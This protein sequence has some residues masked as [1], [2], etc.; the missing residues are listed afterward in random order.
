MRRHTLKGVASAA[1]EADTPAFQAGVGH[2]PMITDVDHVGV[3]VRSLD[4]ALAFYRDA[5]GLPLVKEED[6]PARGARVALLAAGASYVEIIQP[7]SPASPFAEHIAERGEG[8]HHLALRSD[9]IDAD[10]TRLRQLGVALA[11][12][13]PRQGITGRLSYLAPEAFDGAQIEVVQPE[14]GMDGRTPAASRI[15]R[16]DH[17]VL[18]AP[19]VPEVS[20][21]FQEWFGIVTKRTMERGTRRFAFMR[22]GEV[23][24]EVIGPLAPGAAGSGLV[25]G[26]AFEVKGIDALAASLRE[27]GYPAG[28][29]HP[30]LQGGRIASVHPSG[31]CG[32]PVAFIDFTGSPR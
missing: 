29:P 18:H 13:E 2:H 8:L 22:P 28:D 7:T 11:D 26:L 24:I 30:A 4:G 17:I 19:D 10:V 31:A 27:K 6:A 32:V 25:A 16:I 15:T 3:A 1:E 5:L 14:P 23:V 20:R 21:R 12:S 9:G